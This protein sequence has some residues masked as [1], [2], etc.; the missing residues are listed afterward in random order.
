MSSLTTLELIES[1]FAS[2][3]GQLE[4]FC[5]LQSTMVFSVLAGL[6]IGTRDSLGRPLGK[7][8]AGNVL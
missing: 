4:P 6:E 1:M 8:V 3:Q 7:Q 2:V 5:T